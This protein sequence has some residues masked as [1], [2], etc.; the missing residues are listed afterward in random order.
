MAYGFQDVELFSPGGESV[1]C[2]DLIAS[3][4][5][6]ENIGAAEASLLASMGCVPG[7]LIPQEEI[8]WTSSVPDSP[9]EV[10][11]FVEPIQPAWTAPTIQQEK[12]IVNTEPAFEDNPISWLAPVVTASGPLAAAFTS[13]APQGGDSIFNQIEKIAR[14]TLPMF[15]Q[16]DQFTQ[17]PGGTP[18]CIPRNVRDLSCYNPKFKNSKRRKLRLV[19][20]PDG[21]MHPE[22]YCT[23][24]R[25]NPLNP[26]ALS[27][28]ARRLGS[29]QRIAGNI[30]K[31]IQRS[32]KK[33]LGR[34]RSSSRVPTRYMGPPRRKRAS[35]GPWACR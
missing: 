25:M 27:R 14:D 21:Q 11:G 19:C 16:P 35:C 22:V 28:A 8:G 32:C 17:L 15:F 7:E 31:M 13:Q 10:G 6:W 30:E 26:R 23:P 33:G 2:S 1:H 3:R 5:G 34:G 29:F 18:S 12:P 20:G 4:G 24:K 9:G